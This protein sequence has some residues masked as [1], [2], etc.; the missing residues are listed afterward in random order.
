MSDEN[1]DKNTNQ[2]N[3]PKPI[4]EQYAQLKT[5]YDT[6]YGE[7]TT[8]TKENGKLSTELKTIKAQLDE[9]KKLE[10]FKDLNPDRVGEYLQVDE[11]I[12]AK[13]IEIEKV[14]SK[15]KKQIEDLRKELENQLNT[16]KAAKSSLQVEYDTYR[17]NSIIL[18][19]LPE[20][21]KGA[22]KKHLLE[23]LSKQF[24]NDADHPGEIKFIRRP[25]DPMTGKKTTV[26]EA[27]DILREDPDFAFYFP[28][29]S[30]NGSDSH[31]SNTNTTGAFR[32]SGNPEADWKAA[33]ENRT[34]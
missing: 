28:A 6:V 23:M 29:K 3:D 14:E 18:E 27:I 34:Q 4:E 2:G 21:N 16:E 19:N 9:I 13:G 12:K 8:L 20:L 5:L 25:E 24:E 30:A 17:K 1:K 31:G 10:A 7:K 33:K 26:T 32:L 15:Y 22:P 11:I